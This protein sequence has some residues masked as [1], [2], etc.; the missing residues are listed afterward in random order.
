MMPNAVCYSSRAFDNRA[1]AIMMNKAEDALGGAK[2]ELG[3]CGGGTGEVRGRRMVCARR[4]VRRSDNGS[5]ARQ[6]VRR[7]Q[8]SRLRLVCL[9]WAQA[10]AGES[11][12]LRSREGGH[13]E[14]RGH[15]LGQDD[16]RSRARV[17]A[18]RA[19]PAE[20]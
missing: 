18:S 12:L 8:W 11:R 7:C 10:D 13:E 9:R 6:R 15:R 20:G 4:R 1:R 17:G 3:R 19:Q 14:R 2:A 5:N 16:R